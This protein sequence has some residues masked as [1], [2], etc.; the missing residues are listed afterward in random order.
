[1]GPPDSRPLSRW[2]EEPGLG[3]VASIAQANCWTPSG[4][5]YLGRQCCLMG[6]GLAGRLAHQM[7]GDAE[8]LGDDGEGGV[9]GGGGGEEGGVD[10][11]EVVEVVGIAEGVEDG[12][13]G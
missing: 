1:M 8:G 4:R 3:P 6:R 12:G 10:D 11:V 5:R 13:G 9:D 2:G 7:V